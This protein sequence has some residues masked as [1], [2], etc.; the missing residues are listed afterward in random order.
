LQLSRSGKKVSKYDNPKHLAKHDKKLKRK[1]QKLARK[2]KASNSRYNIEKLLPKYT[3]GLVI[4]GN[5]FYINL[6]ISWSAIASWS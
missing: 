4:H 2:Q 5:I 6:V 1:Q 3:N